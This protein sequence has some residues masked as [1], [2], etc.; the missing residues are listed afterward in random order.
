MRFKD[1]EPIE[2]HQCGEMIYAGEAYLEWNKD[3][4]CSEECVAEAMLDYYYCDVHERSLET[5]EDKEMT[6]ADMM[7][8]ERKCEEYENK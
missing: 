5:A 3:N 2:C 4:Y 7:Y 6:Y 8:A 1:D